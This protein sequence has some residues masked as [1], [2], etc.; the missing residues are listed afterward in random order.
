MQ[1]LSS[2]ERQALRG[3]AHALHP[4]V[5]ISEKGLSETVLKEIDRC[6]TA[7]EL[8]KIRVFN[9]QQEDREAYLDEICARLGA[10]SIQHIGKILVL[11]RAR[12]E[13]PLPADPS[14]K[15]RAGKASTERRLTGKARSISPR[16]T[17]AG[18]KQ[19]DNKA[20]SPSGGRSGRRKG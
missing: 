14:T 10:A 9:D 17:G 15:A 13:K 2:A 11:Y 6:L 1:T 5:A 16:S 12:L 19:T 8:I 20:A 7:H 4:V 3:R 18:D